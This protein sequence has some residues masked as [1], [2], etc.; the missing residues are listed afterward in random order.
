MGWFLYDKDL[1]HDRVKTEIDRIKGTKVD[2][3][4]VLIKTGILQVHIRNIFCP[5]DEKVTIC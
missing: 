4:Y 2:N 1:R 3:E 5:S